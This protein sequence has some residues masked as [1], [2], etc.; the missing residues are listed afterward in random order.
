MKTIKLRSGR[1]G[2]YEDSAPVLVEQGELELRVEFPARSGKFF[3]VTDLNNKSGGAKLIPPNG[4][5]SVAITEAGELCA[6]VKH[7][8]RGELIEIF[9]I[10]P[11]LIKSVEKTLSATPE[12]AFL[13]GEIAALKDRAETLEKALT[14]ME[15][16]AEEADRR[17][18]EADKR[19]A[20]LTD[21]A[22][23]AYRHNVQLNAHDLTREE[24]EKTILNNQEEQL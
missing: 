22:Y 4:L 16:R 15:K 19:I 1:I 21:Y 6:A 18:E 23:L 14:D 11:L 10:E 3:L 5:I 20:A 9:Q 2:R 24:F 13:T 7:Y 8:L 17:A 12:Y